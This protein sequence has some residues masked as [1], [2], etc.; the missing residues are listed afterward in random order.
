MENTKIENHRIRKHYA[1]Y[2]QKNTP[3]QIPIKEVVFI[4]N[5]QGKLEDDG[6]GKIVGYKN[7]NEYK[8]RLK[9]ERGNPTIW[10][11]RI[12]RANQYGKKVQ[13]IND[14]NNYNDFANWLEKKEAK[15]LEFLINLHGT[16]KGQMMHDKHLLILE[17]KAS[18]KYSI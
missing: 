2:T 18:K 9:R 6:I 4:K 1:H 17:E 14:E 5:S 3:T 10:L 7:S 15:Y 12:H 16:E 8:N 11:E 13:L